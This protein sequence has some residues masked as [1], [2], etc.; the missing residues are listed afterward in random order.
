MV[1][2]RLKTNVNGVSDGAMDIRV[3]RTKT[4]YKFIEAY[5]IS[6]KF[7]FC[8]FDLGDWLAEDIKEYSNMTDV[9]S[10][11]KMLSEAVSKPI[12]DLRAY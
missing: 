2:R 6:G 5:N 12:I 7:S 4:G 1:K 9:N 3:G 11:V 8:D 10:V